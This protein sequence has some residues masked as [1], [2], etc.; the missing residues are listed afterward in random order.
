MDFG[1]LTLLVLAGV[2]GPL[3]AAGDRP[4]VP[5]MVGEIL[6]G[7]VLGVTGLGIIDPAEPTVKFLAEV[8]FALLMLRAGMK[9]PV[10]DHDLR[11]ALG[12]GSV[13]ALVVAVVALP[14]AWLIAATAG[15][16]HVGVWLLLLATGSAAVVL[17]AL[18][19]SGLSGPATLVVMAQV[20]VADIATI[21]AVPL[22][23][24]PER[25]ARAALGGATITLAA[26]GIVVVS[27]R[28]RSLAP[29]GTFRRWSAERGWGLDLRMSLL[30]LFGLAWLAERFG[31]SVLVAGFAVGLVV[32]VLGEP[33]RFGWEIVG[34]GNGFLVPIFFVVLGARLDL[35]SLAD[36]PAALGLAAV[37]V[38]GNL[39]AHLVGALVTG[40]PWVTSLLSSAQM[41]VPIAV[42]AIGLTNGVLSEQQGVAVVLAALVSLGVAS[43]GAR[44]LSSGLGAAA[45]A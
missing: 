19:D 20:T 43:V 34:V 17:P 39:L 41:G 9:V 4:V 33:S 40:Q 45:P 28:V 23:L 6:A 31:I 11:N 42:A 38:V 30:W 22:V 29:A 12:A 18:D 5:V 14:V 15:D 13:A 10:R 3:L 7:V 1:L 27:R 2:A 44:R 26:V 8:G 37:L 16:G 36:H 35:R 32:S 24:Q 25:A 21:V